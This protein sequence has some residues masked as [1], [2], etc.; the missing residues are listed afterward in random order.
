MNACDQAGR[1]NPDGQQQGEV[2]AGL[3]LDDRGLAGCLGRKPPSWYRTVVSHRG[4]KSGR[5]RGRGF[6]E[7]LSAGGEFSRQREEKN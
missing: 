7:A 1:V 3:I 2:K 4:M 5:P 6:G